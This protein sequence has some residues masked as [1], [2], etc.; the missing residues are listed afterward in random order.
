LVV[1]YKKNFYVRKRTGKDIWQNLYE[2][3]LL[4]TPKAFTIKSLQT[5]EGFKLLFGNEQPKIKSVSQVYKQQLT[6]QT[7]N[8][9]FLNISIERPM[10]LKG[11]ELIAPEKIK[12]LPFPKFI[13]T[14]LKD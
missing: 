13:T 6:H 11:Y 1:E 10:G 9:Q 7:I 2:F 4:E 3:I 8:G 12:E 5:S 14:F